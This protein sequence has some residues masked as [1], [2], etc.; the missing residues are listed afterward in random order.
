MFQ[1]TYTFG[2]SKTDYIKVADVSMIFFA[3]C[4]YVYNNSIILGSPI[5]ANKRMESPIPQLPSHNAGILRQ[6][7]K[8]GF[9]QNGSWKFGI[10]SHSWDIG[11]LSQLHSPQLPQEI[12]E[13]SENRIWQ[14]TE[15][16]TCF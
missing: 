9:N 13:S 5:E 15:L 10:F 2:E 4:T 1:V 12:E 3:I 7:P 6:S 8:K 14:D 11:Q 16:N